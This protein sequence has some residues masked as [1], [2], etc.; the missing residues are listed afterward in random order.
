[1]KYLPT[2]LLAILVFSSC[3]NPETSNA[4][5]NSNAEPSQ[6]QITNEAFAAFLDQFAEVN[7][8]VQIR[9]CDVD[10]SNM[11]AFDESN[12]SQFL[13]QISFAYG[14][15]P[16]NGDYLTIIS[17]TAADCLLPVLS[18][19]NYNGDLIDRKTIAIGQ[20]GMAP[21][22]ECVEFMSLNSNFELYTVDTITTAQC[23]DQYQPIAG[24][25]KTKIIYR[26]GHL[27]RTG[28]IALS[29]ISEEPM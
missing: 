10:Y 2:L 28:T 17:L 27:T 18:T 4:E 11:T 9:A 1:M 12:K 7:L 13:D 20:C 25:E 14:K 19:F 24:T 29:G 22:F 5:N 6:P 23:D 8:P 26:E 15:I 16:S 21:C 3:G